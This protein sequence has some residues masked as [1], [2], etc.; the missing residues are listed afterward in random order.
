MCAEHQSKDQVSTTGRDNQKEQKRTWLDIIEKIGT[1]VAAL[2]AAFAAYFIAQPFQ[3]EIAGVTLLSQR[4][5]AESQLRADMFSSLIGPIVGPNQ[6]KD[7]PAERQKILVELL[8]LNFNEYFEFKPLLESV[9]KQLTTHESRQSLRSI[10]RRIIDRQVAGLQK[11]N[12]D[13][14][15]DAKVYTF[16]VTEDPQND[17]EKEEFVKLLKQSGTTLYVM[18]DIGSAEFVKVTSQDN[19]HTFEINMREAKWEENTFQVHIKDNENVV[20]PVIT[21]SWADLPLTDNTFLPDGN[22]FAVVCYKTITD[23]PLKYAIFKFIWFPKD[24]YTPRERPIDQKKFLDLIG[25]KTGK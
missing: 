21:S 22:R 2:I 1:P 23:N 15:S 12:G 24:Y 6:D 13:G 7:I 3:R 18:R 9:D 5:T 16:Y 25:K 14:V 10:I 8:A 4:E 20:M 11:N 19:E 17:K